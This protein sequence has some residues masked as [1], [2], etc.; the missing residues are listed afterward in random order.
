MLGIIW[1]NAPVLQHTRVYRH[2]SHCCVCNQLFTLLLPFPLG[3]PSKGARGGR[4]PGRNKGS[5]QM[6][7]SPARPRRGESNKTDRFRSGLLSRPQSHRK[8]RKNKWVPF[9]K[10]PN[11]VWTAI[12]PLKLECQTVQQTRR[13]IAL[14]LAESLKFGSICVPPQRVTT[15]LQLWTKVRLSLQAA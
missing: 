14:S 4:F 10:R 7:V 8:R 6:T 5:L 15:A 9:W 3:R 1:R 2:K 13:F 12:K 11:C